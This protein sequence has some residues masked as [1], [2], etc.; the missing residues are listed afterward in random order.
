MFANIASCCWV[1]LRIARPS[2]VLLGIAGYC[3][4]LLAVACVF[5]GVAK[6]CQVQLGVASKLLLGNPLLLG[7]VWYC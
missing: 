4:V 5:L 6:N 7:T 2:Y 1:L 3:S